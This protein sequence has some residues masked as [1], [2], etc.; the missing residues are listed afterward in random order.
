MAMDAH[1]LFG[2]PMPQ[3]LKAITIATNQ[4][5]A[6]T[7]ATSVFIMVG[8]DVNNKRLVVKPLTINLPDCKQIQSTHVYDI[9]IPGLP[10]LLTG[11]IVTSLS[12]ASLI[13]IR[14]LCKAGCKVI[15]DNKKW[16]VMFKG[17]VISRGFKDPSTDLRT[18]PIL[19]K[20]CSAPGPT[21]LL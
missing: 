1:A 16:D 6:N 9:Q 2:N 20:V 12:I 4:A 8:M 7:G 15:F 11:H 13:G 14:P 19:T 5:I 17:V 21:V 18:L 10:T 3:Y